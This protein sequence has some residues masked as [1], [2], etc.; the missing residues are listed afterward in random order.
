M[1]MVMRNLADAGMTMLVVTHEMQLAQEAADR[2]FHGWWDCGEKC[3]CKRLFLR[4]KRGANPAVSLAVLN[5]PERKLGADI[6][7]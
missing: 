5:R 7:F 1:L 6:S 2:D 4:S 3:R